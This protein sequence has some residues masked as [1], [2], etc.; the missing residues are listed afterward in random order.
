MTQQPPEAGDLR[1]AL[2][3]FGIDAT[4][5][6]DGGDTLTAARRSA[7]ALTIASPAFGP[8]AWLG[9]SDAYAQVQ[10]MIVELLGEGATEFSAVGAALIT[11][12][13][14]YQREEDANVHMIKKIW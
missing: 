7:E 12:R 1:A 5:W 3:Q 8:A 14:T 2:E 13:D 11:A 10:Q 9:L 6:D 4:R